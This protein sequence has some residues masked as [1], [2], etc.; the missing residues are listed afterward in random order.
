MW[1]I[2]LIII[3]L[4]AGC[5]FPPL[6]VLVLC[7]LGILLVLLALGVTIGSIQGLWQGLAAPKEPPP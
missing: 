3:L 7:G 4:V 6:L 2:G 5:F 1:I